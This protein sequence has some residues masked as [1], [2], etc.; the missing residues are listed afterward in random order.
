[1]ASNAVD[2]AFAPAPTPQSLGEILDSADDGPEDA[3][4]ITDQQEDPTTDSA[5]KDGFCV[6]CEDQAA[7]VHCESCE[8]AF[9]DVCFT[10][11]HSK[12]RKHHIRRPLPKV[13]KKNI[14][15]GNG[16][17]PTAP[18]GHAGDETPCFSDDAGIDGHGDWFIERAKYTPLRLTM[19]E[20]KL[21]RLLEA[22]LEVSEY[23]DKIGAA[24]SVFKPKRIVHQIKELCSILSG[25]VIA[26]DYK[27]GQEL[28]AE[29][30]FESNEGF[31]KT[32]FELGRR[33]KILNPDKART[34]Y[35]KLIYLV[36]DAQDPAVADIPIRNVYD[37]LDS[38]DAL[39]L[40]RDNRV[41]VATQEVIAEGRPRHEIQKDIKAKE[42]AIETL[43]RTHSKGKLDPETIRQALYSIGDNHAFLRVN[44]DPCDKM[45]AYLKKY[46]DPA[47]P[48]TSGA[49]SLAI[50]SGR[51]GARLSHDHAKQYQYVLQSLTLW[52]EVLHDMFR[53]WSLAEED[54]LNPAIPYRLRDTGQGLN[55]MAQAPKTVRMMQLILQRA[56]KSLGHWVGSSVIHMGDHN[57]PNAFMFIDKYSQIYR[58]L[59]PICTTISLIPELL[60]KPA[61][62][63]YIEAEFGDIDSLIREILA[64]FFRHGFDGSGADSFYDAG[65]CIDGRLTSAWNW[66]S[67]LEKKRYFPV[68][69]LCGF[70]GFDGEW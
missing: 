67:L 11:Q 60:E 70:A 64:D 2:I 56:Q 1:M 3:V 20:R 52:R 59:L 25:L 39:D 16:R 29:R 34:T 32:V 33:Y 18:N 51:G 55:R 27:R 24:V 7:E 50:R 17:T 68:F 61:L 62:K 38:C 36:M 47:S 10:S 44:R 22:A 30:D 13:T 35:G 48:G 31:Y 49:T 5:P 26:S 45:I 8:N 58:I 42:R 23:T 6:E 28:F 21:L 43:A 66:C 9:C 19:D 54:L 4:I 41:S 53:L 12:S 37:L 63:K 46:F 65:S 69:L 40:L 57:V 14:P 15:D